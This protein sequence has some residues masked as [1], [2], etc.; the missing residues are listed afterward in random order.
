MGWMKSQKGIL[1]SF[2][3]WPKEEEE[4][5]KTLEVQ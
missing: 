3:L 1:G 2:P 4:E 5:D